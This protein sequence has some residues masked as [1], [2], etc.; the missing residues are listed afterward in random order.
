M[1]GE[2]QRGAVEEGNRKRV[3]RIVEQVAIGQREIVGPFQMGKNPERYRLR[4]FVH[5][6]RTD[7]ANHQI[8]PD[9][10]QEGP[11]HMRAH[12]QRPRPAIGPHPPEQDRSGQEESGQD[13]PSALVERHERREAIFRCRR[14]ERQPEELADELDRAPVDRRQHVEPDDLDREETE[15]QRGDAQPAE[16]DRTD[17]RLAELAH[18]VAE[19]GAPGAV[20]GFARRQRDAHFG[21]MSQ[22]HLRKDILIS[23]HLTILPLKTKSEC[24]ATI[25]TIPASLRHRAVRQ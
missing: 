7:E 5:E 1:H 25:P 22:L 4:P 24:C 15:Q 9:R 14:A 18:P 10:A 8:Q 21:G 2:Q 19:A 13:P 12:A 3:E 11:G 23:C 17:L 6:E 20:T 16:I